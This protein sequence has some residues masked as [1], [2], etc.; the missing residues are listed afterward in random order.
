MAGNVAQS[1]PPYETAIGPSRYHAVLVALHW[2]SAV[3]IFASLASGMLWL[4]ETPNSSP[5]KIPQLGVHMAFGLL[6]LLLVIAQLA[7]RLLAARPA[8]ATAGNVWLDRL[9]LLTHYSL[10]AA[11]VLMA[12]SGI[13]TALAAG[14]PEILFGGS[15]RA[16]PE[17]FYIYAPRIAHGLLANVVI[18]LILLHLL[19]VLYHYVVREDRLLRRMWFGRR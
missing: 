16:L 4:N 18:A 8:P 10:Y 7:A 1:Q 14:L 5:D 11:V 6:I 2:A 3:L 13:A 17:T 19:G 9:A 12:V 15:D